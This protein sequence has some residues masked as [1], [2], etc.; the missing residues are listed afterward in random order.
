VLGQQVDHGIVFQFAQAAADVVH[1]MVVAVDLLRLADELR[2]VLHGGDL[3]LAVHRLAVAEF[4]QREAAMVGVAELADEGQNR[5]QV[6]DLDVVAD[7]DPVVAQ[8]LAQERHLHRLLLDQV[9]DGLVQVARADA[10]VAGEMEPVVAAQQGG[11][12]G[13]ADAGHAQQGDLLVLPGAE[14]F[15][16][17]FHRLEL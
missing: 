5:P 2:D 9:E 4:R 8:Q 12:V 13:L 16:A 15:G 1:E 11:D 10:V 7:V 6:L 14:G 17:E 3:R